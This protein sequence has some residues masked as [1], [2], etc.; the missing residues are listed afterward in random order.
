MMGGSARVL[1]V[2]LSKTPEGEL[3]ELL[4]AQGFETSR[5]SIRGCANELTGN[6]RPDI[7][8]LD[9]QSDEAKSDMISF[10]SLARSLKKSALGSHMRVM[11][12]GSGQA[13]MLEGALD[14]VDDLLVGPI[15]AA[16]IAHRL[17]A[18][19]R[20]NTMHEELVRRLNTSARYGADAPKV[21]P[22]PQ[23]ENPTILVLGQAVDLGPIEH[24]LAQQATLV[25]ALTV[26]TALDYL[27]RQPFEAIIINYSSALG[28]RIESA[29]PELAH[30]L[31]FARDM[32]RDSRLYN[33][34]L[35]LLADPDCLAEAD[36]IYDAGITDIIAK[37]FAAH[38]LMVRVDRLVR[39]LRFRDSLKH[40][41]GQAKHFA[42]SDALT[43]LYSRG[44]LLEHLATV[45]A[46]AEHTSQ[47]F[48]V[49]GFSVANIADVNEALGYAGGDRVIRQVGEV[50]SFL[51]RGEDLAARYSGSRFALLL[52]D[53][54][55]ESASHAVKRIRGVVAHTEFAIEGVDCPVHISLASHIAGYRKGDSAED[56]LA[57]LWTAGSDM[58]A[59]A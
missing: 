39:E 1:I 16:Q 52:P 8:M 44:F 53:T 7:V 47:S 50:V 46:D 25:G 21:T 6:R 55:A 11:V 10:L 40:V 19:V 49:A 20:L 12:V 4:A 9:L 2:G 36:D 51:V 18:L 41:Y 13:N 5:I 35:L 27:S 33:I 23:V 28:R 17:R 15:N 32:R 58:S 56:M 3:T 14:G 34:P 30:Y 54:T 22:P 45:I 43:G 29:M 24:A 48:S 57:R 26:P 59:A 38:E 31:D 42:T 37:P